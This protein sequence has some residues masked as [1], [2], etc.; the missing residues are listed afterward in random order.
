MT[1]SS[2]R[3]G[4]SHGFTLIEV[5]LVI[6]IMAVMAAVIAP[7]FFAASGPSVE[8]EARRLVRLLRLAADEAALSGLPVRFAAFPHRYAFESPDAEGVW[9]ERV[10]EPY[11]P[12]DLPLSMRIDSVEPAHLPETP[13][14]THGKQDEPPLGHLVFLPLGVIEP[15]RIRLIREGENPTEAIIRLQ[16][17]PGGIRLERQEN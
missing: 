8:D 7:S 13:V 17:G 1:L 5:L 16:P 2:G 15:A 9:Q 10:D 11:G 3:S 6:V 14:D 12:H 4:Q